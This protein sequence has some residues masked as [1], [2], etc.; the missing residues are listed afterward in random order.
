ME[1]AIYQH[2]PLSRVEK[3]Q[4]VIQHADPLG[5]GS[6][7]PQQALLVQLEVLSENIPIPSLARHAIEEG[8]DFLFRR[9]YHELGHLLGFLPCALRKSRFSSVA[10]LILIQRGLVG[11][12][13]INP[14]LIS[15]KHITHRISS[16]PY[17][18][19]PR[20]HHWL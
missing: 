1:I 2:V 5:V 15:K 19:N 4:Q 20:M 16:S 18:A 6:T 11:A 10:T 7:N 17:Q 3:V 14:R 12:K 9:Q 13:S 8:M